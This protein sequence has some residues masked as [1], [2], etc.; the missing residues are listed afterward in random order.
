MV[1][2]GIFVAVLLSTSAAR[3]HFIWL[4]SSLTDAG[5]RAVISFGESAFEEDYNLPESVESCSL[6][7]RGAQTA[8][9]GALNAESLDAESLNKGGGEKT[10]PLVTE[11]VETD[12]RIVLEASLPSGDPRV[13]E[14]TCTYG[15]YHGSLLQYYAKHIHCKSAEELGNFGPSKSLKLDLVPRNTEAG[16]ELTVYWEGQPLPDVKLTLAAR[17][18]DE[19]DEKQT[20]TTDKEGR[21]AFSTPAKGLVSVLG[22]YLEKKD[23]EKKVTGE[24]DGEAYKSIAHYATL[25]FASHA[26]ALPTEKGTVSAPALVS[27]QEL[28]KGKIPALPEA[29][30]SF[31]AAVHEGWL[32]VY[33]GHT[34]TAH[35]HSVENLSP[36]FCRL[37]LDGGK[38]WEMLPMEKPLQGIPLVA[39]GKSLYR[40]GDLPLERKTGCDWRD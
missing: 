6:W 15:L 7:W 34:G 3:A 1:A 27:K 36:H 9:K 13:L 26:E 28:A 35:A 16:I 8:D 31:G 2:L 30:A 18:S 5:T 4:K 23:V 33:G 25:T 11:R 37:Q 40:I 14:A 10:H 24:L 22:H 29:V 21:V 12:D 20:G 38:A 17:G 19:E 32:Y 39:H